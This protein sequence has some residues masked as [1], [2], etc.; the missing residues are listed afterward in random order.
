MAN[1]PP[2]ETV[3]LLHF[4]CLF[5][6]F[7]LFLVQRKNR[8]RPSNSNRPSQKALLSQC[9]IL[10][11]TNCHPQPMSTL[12]R[13]AFYLRGKNGEQ[14]KNRKIIW[15]IIKVGIFVIQCCPLRFTHHGQEEHL[16]AAKVR[17]TLSPSS[18]AFQA[19]QGTG[20]TRHPPPHSLRQLCNETPAGWTHRGSAQKHLLPPGYGTADGSGTT[21]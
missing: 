13:D 15:K 3:T 8:N 4:F 1:C 17:G 19:L 14:T 11:N 12:S 18:G 2:Q 7:T 21:K 5:L 6:C 10:G 9:M 20:L 16:L